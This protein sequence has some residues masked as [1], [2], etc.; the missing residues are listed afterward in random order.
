MTKRL[1]AAELKAELE[2]DSGF[3]AEQ[4]RRDQQME[5]RRQALR[6]AERPLLQ[7]LQA[8]GVRVG[9]VWDLVNQSQGYKAAVPVL[10]DHLGRGYPMEVRE[11]IARALGVPSASCYWGSLVTS[12]RRESD[13]RVKDG[14]AAAISSIGNSENWQEL[15]DL[16]RDRANGPSRVMLLRVLLRGGEPGRAE[17]EKLSSDPDLAAEAAFLLRTN[18]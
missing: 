13:P 16:L 4:Q 9:S 5:I 10:I 3:V 7:E 2:R 8:V 14:L 15:L 1:T 6:D 18:R 12:Y 17:L 11:G